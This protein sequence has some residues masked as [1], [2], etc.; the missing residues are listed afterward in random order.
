VLLA[1]TVHAEL[2]G[3]RPEDVKVNVKNGVLTLEGIGV[4]NPIVL[5]LQLTRLCNLFA[6]ERKQRDVKDKGGYKLVERVYGSFYRAFALPDNADSKDVKG[7]HP[8]QSM[9]LI[10]NIVSCL[11]VCLE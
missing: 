1:I 2:A 5:V 7:I 9:T 4:A 8:K 3:V 10:L 6:G 11:F